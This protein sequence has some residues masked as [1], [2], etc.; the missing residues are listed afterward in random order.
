MIRYFA[1]HPTAANLMMLAILILGL[2]ALPQLQRDTFPTIP[3]SEVE[4]RVAYPGATPAEV[5]DA[6]CQRIEDSLDSVTDLIEVRCDAREN[7]AIATAEMRSVADLGTFYDDV[8]SQVEAITTFPQ[9]AKS[10]SVVKLERTAVVASIAITGDMQAS[11]L[12]AYAEQI[13]DRIKRDRRIA[14]VMVKGFADQNIA[15]DIPAQA[16]HRYGLSISDVTAAIERQ[17]L[18]MPAGVMETSGGDWIVRFAG[19]RRS[20]F[21]FKNLVVVSSP[22][23]GRVFLGDVATIAVEFD[24]Q[25]DKVLFNGQRAALLEI[26]KTEDQDALR[27]MAAV[28]E[29]LEREQAMAPKGVQL[30]ISQD[31]TSNVRDRLRLLTE[32]GIMGLILVFL[33]MWAFF[34]LRFSFWVAMGL[35]VS[36]LGAIF[37]MSF[38]GYT[39][40]MITMV[41]LLVAI[42]LLMDDAIVI[43][44]NIAAQA[45][46]GK[47][48]LDA[49]VD[50]TRQV[51]PGVMASFITTILIVGPL[52][53]MAGKM[54]AVLKYLPIILVVTLTVSLIEAFLILPAH[55]RHAVEQSHGDD[56]NRVQ[57]W[58][59]AKFNHLR[60]HV[61]GP[62]VDRAV[63]RPYLTVGSLLGLALI[64]FATIGGGLLKFQAFPDLE[65]DTIQAR[66]LLPQGT[67]L[68]RTEEVVS[69]V[70]TALKQL[71][72]EFNARQDKGRRLVR[73]VTT[74]YNTNID[75]FE[76]GPH[77]ATISADLLRAEER[78][79]KVNEMLGR[80]RELVGDVPDVIGFKFT[81]KERGVA[82]KA[83]DVRLLG[84]NLDQL[85]Q[86]SLDLQA[87]FAGFKGVLDLSDDLRPGKPEYQISLKDTAGSFGVTAR[88]VA[89][90]VRAAVQGSTSL[91]IAAGNETYDVV[92]RLSGHDLDGLVDLRE[93]T[94]TAAD[95][96]QVPL[97]AVA[98]VTETRGYARINRIDGTRTVT[99]QGKLDTNV[100]NARE[101]MGAMK[102]QFAPQLKEKYPNVRFS[103]Q[104]QDK[105][106]AETGGSLQTKLII[107]LVGI[108]L[109]LAFQFKSYVQP[110]AVVLSIPM[111]AIGVIWGHL[112][113]GHDLTMPSLVGLATLAG[114]VV[115]DNILLVAF[116]KGRLAEGE[117]I[118]HAARHAARDRF[119]AIMLTS[120][121]TIAGLTPLL[122]ETSTQAQFLIPLVVSLIF[123]LL[124]ATLL[125]LFMVPSMFV[126][127]HDL[128][129]LKAQEQVGQSVSDNPS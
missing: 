79:G 80:W 33:M 18:D 76:S 58:V 31:T 34:S 23:G 122:L 35:P 90:E 124:S 95:G 107:G 70:D 93:L 2:A 29:N 36:F 125:A 13:K 123:G 61:L 60:D 50:G 88:A 104:G 27:V 117:D 97:F 72:E 39:I 126:I 65:S 12:K 94:I 114:I 98:D 9:E 25:E 4:I 85:K 106:S 91:E 99:I 102:K 1:Q 53:F 75:A 8:K 87:W 110:L 54:G 19:Q 71:D 86:A 103:S 83:I 81:D 47:N 17:S 51:L 44:E 5:E 16:L 37:A 73:N 62:W 59:D 96:R 120:L 105:E 11:M 28:Q 45:R 82:G 89:A 63:K 48:A 14:Q 10:P 101:L 40:N 57:R 30:A 43:S 68:S 56:R 20:A 55:L 115:N 7:I 74:Q 15:V 77:I 38:L 109:V 24:Q 118:E 64:S 121:T 42:G 119:R 128:G 26:I 78:N 21:D 100:A 113:L 66:I 69:I 127:L 112:L 67:P 22:S 129:L 111:A 84:N 3:A 41:A 32:N 46:K 92:V 6:V 116:I 52:G 108:F 49:V